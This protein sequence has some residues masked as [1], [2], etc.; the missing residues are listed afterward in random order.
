LENRESGMDQDIV[1]LKD[2][3]PSNDSKSTY[4]KKLVSVRPSGILL[5]RKKWVPAVRTGLKPKLSIGEA[6]G[7]FALMNKGCQNSGPK[8]I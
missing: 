5:A 1:Q 3:I 6:S 4:I 2:S 7:M 8:P